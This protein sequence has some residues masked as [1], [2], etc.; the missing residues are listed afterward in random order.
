MLQF[1][2][3]QKLDEF[4]SRDWGRVRVRTEIRDSIGPAIT[5]DVTNR[6]VMAA[7]RRFNALNRIETLPSPSKS[8][9]IRHSPV[10]IPG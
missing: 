3:V 9:A 2:Q 1:V 5:V 6:I 8:G 7:A 4:A 10:G